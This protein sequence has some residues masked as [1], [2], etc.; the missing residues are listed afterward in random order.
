M[1]RSGRLLLL[2]PLLLFC[3]GAKLD[4]IEKM[5]AEGDHAKVVEQIAD[6]KAKGALGKEEA[7]L[8]AAMA[9][10]AFELAKADG[11]AAALRQFIDLLGKAGV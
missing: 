9:K 7:E 3:L 11:K 4:K 6:W 8:L 2:S 10:S 5:Q 1:S